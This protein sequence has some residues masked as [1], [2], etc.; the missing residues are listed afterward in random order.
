MYAS[1]SKAIFSK[2][3]NKTVSTTIGRYTIATY[4]LEI[5]II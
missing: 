3:I 4:F 5:S 1:G 2:I